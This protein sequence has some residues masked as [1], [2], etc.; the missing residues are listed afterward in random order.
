MIHL[1][2]RS[3]LR[4]GAFALLVIGIAFI[5][6]FPLYV[7]A[8]NAF[9]EDPEITGRPAWPWSPIPKTFTTEWVYSLLTESKLLS[10]L[11]LTIVSTLL[12]VGISLLLATPAAWALVRVGG[13]T[14][15]RFR[16]TG[17]ILTFAVISRMFPSITVGIPLAVILVRLMLHDTIWGLAIGFTLFSLPYSLIVMKSQFEAIPPELEEAA[18]VDGYSRFGAFIR[19]TLPPAAPG[20]AAAAIFS[21]LFAWGELTLPLLITSANQP[22][23]VMTW[24]YL[25]G[26]TMAQGSAIAFIQLIPVL[27][28]TY[29]LQRFLK[30]EYLAGAFKY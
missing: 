22:L 30:P 20:M 29:I 7:V 25:R 19:V 27:I 24:R 23:S 21:F 26:A 1:K 13:K 5:I 16:A 4:S 3:F 2:S 28:F 9:V 10:S 14:K 11:M 15:T 18:M 8:K 17:F 6:V 12:S